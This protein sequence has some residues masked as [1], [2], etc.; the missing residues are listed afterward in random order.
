MTKKYVYE[1]EIKHNDNKKKLI[2]IDINEMTDMVND[3]LNQ[4]DYKKRYNKYQLG[5]YIYKKC[6]T[7]LIFNY[8]HKI[9]VKEYFKD[10]IEIDYIENRTIQSVNRRLRMLCDTIGECECE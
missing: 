8:I 6:K 10:S 9:E 5:N 2:T 1:C 7:P 3:F 4:T